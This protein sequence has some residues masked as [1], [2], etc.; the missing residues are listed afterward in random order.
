MKFKLRLIFFITLL[1][2]TLRLFVINQ[3]FWL[4]EATSATVATQYNFSQ[5]IAFSK[6]D[7]HPP[8]YYFFMK[9][10][11]SAFGYTEVSLRMPSI[12][13]SLITPLVKRM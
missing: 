5:I 6:G 10:W 3:S 4:D 12:L 9:A 8:L 13:F 2:L 7:F 11:T 1:G